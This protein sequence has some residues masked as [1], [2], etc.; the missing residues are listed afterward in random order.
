MRAR[1]LALAALAL[2]VA[3][4]VAAHVAYDVATACASSACAIN[5]PHLVEVDKGQPCW[6]CH[7]DV[8]GPCVHC[9][10]NGPTPEPHAR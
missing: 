4:W 1:R 8:P 10:W 7:E 5:A 2:I 3:G 9:H 6:S